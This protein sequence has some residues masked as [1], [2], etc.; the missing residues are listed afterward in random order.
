MS[1]LVT[2]TLG[3]RGSRGTPLGA[4]F[5][6]VARLRRTKSDTTFPIV[7][8]RAAAIDRAAARTS[9]SRSNVVLMPQSSNI[10]HQM[11]TGHR[12]IPRRLCPRTPHLLGKSSRSYG[13]LR[14]QTTFRIAIK[15]SL[16]SGCTSQKKLKIAGTVEE[17]LRT[18]YVFTAIS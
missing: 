11:S 1:S 9:S 16:Q 4:F 7:C 5:S 14:L 17:M 8:F 13:T 3:R 15:E 6:L 2:I 10:T 12:R 18:A